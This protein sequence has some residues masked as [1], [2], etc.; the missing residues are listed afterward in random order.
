MQEKCPMLPPS[1]GP[2]DRASPAGQVNVKEGAWWAE[3]PCC[4]RESC[5]AGRC[6][7]AQSVTSGRL[8]NGANQPRWKCGRRSRKHG[9]RPHV[10]WRASKSSWKRRAGGGAG[11]RQ[12]GG[13]GG[14]QAVSGGVYTVSMWAFTVQAFQLLWRFENFH[15][16]MLAGKKSEK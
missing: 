15:N 8:L 6:R 5:C 2:G 10:R 4:S 11:S 16:M 7:Q 12:V 9:T 13:Q 1:C 3:P 14:E